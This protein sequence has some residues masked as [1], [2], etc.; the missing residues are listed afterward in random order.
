[1]SKIIRTLKKIQEAR[2]KRSTVVPHHENPQ[3]S[4]VSVEDLT[5]ILTAGSLYRKGKPLMSADAAFKEFEILQEKLFKLQEIQGN[6]LLQMGEILG[7]FN[8]PARKGPNKGHS[9]PLP[10]AT[11]THPIV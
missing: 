2:A 11:F 8:S 1:M 9:L 3:T 7:E 4:F 5:D 6:V 10:S